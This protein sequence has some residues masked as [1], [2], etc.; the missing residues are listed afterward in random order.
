MELHRSG[1]SYRWLPAAA[2]R[3]AQRSQVSSLRWSA[4]CEFLP[5]SIVNPHY[6]HQRLTSSCCIFLNM[7]NMEVLKS[8]SDCTTVSLARHVEH[9][10]R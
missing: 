10:N 3:H 1:R 6:L 8:I 9:S 5:P 4:T 2:D 7:V